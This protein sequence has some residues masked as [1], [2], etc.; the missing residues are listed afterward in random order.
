MRASARLSTMKSP[1]ELAATLARQWRDSSVREARL[2]DPREWPIRLPIGRP[3][4]S[5]IRNDT[6]RVRQHLTHWR[7]VAV[8]HV[9]WED[10]PYRAV[11]EPVALPL[12]WVLA[13]P[14]EWARACG[15][16]LVR[17]EQQR[18]QRLLSRVDGSLHSLLVRQVRLWRERPD[19]D[20]EQAAK[21]ALRLEPGMA[22]GQPLRSLSLCGIDS[23]FF[24]RNR[25]L[26]QGM[27]DLRFE[28]QASAL[29]LEA[30]LGAL[31]EGD[32][33]LLVAPL[34]PG[35]LPFAQIR[36]RARE[37]LAKPLPA[38]RICVVENERCLHRLPPVP[39]TIAVL[40]AGLDLAWMRA[41]WLGERRVA[42]WGDIDTW[43]LAMLGRARS[44]QPHVEPVLMDRAVFER[45]AAM[46]VAE[47]MNAGPVAPEGLSAHEQALYAH[48]LALENGRLE[49]EFLPEREVHQAMLAWAKSA[50]YE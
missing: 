25:S 46:A 34:A 18:L 23:K 41:D 19:G 22:A 24:E 40:G 9:E 32:H 27:L 21:L 29:G 15:D 50:R 49:Q 30:F 38:A 39:D 36:L 37:L 42:Y 48:L 4:P 16:P 6:S 5:V 10:V 28:G 33:W 47:P 8:G 1:T 45:N 14:D 26:V 20:V 11:A 17:Q 35:L 44:L 2:L 3:K 7:H 13:T 12:H 31:D 43:G